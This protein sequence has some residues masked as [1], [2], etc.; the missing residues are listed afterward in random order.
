MP[1]T[2]LLLVRHGQST[3]NAD[4]RWQGQADPPLSA[5]GEQQALDAAEHLRGLGLMHVVSSS[6]ERARHTAGLIASSL[7]LGQVEVDER[8][9]ERNFGEFQGLTITEILERWPDHFGESGKVVKSPP[10][11]EE[12]EDVVA[13]T[14]DAMVEVAARHEG[15]RV[16]VVSHGGVIRRL[17]DHLGADL[18][19]TTPNLGGRWWTV[20]GSSREMAPGELLVPLEQTIVTSPTTE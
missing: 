8:L 7:G 2:E 1:P 12:P 3:W 11:A 15:E 13:R 6:L 5:L 10:G 19:P 14:I 20:D 4:G 16:L 9:I 18:P 17:D